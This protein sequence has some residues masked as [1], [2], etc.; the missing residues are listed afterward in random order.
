MKPPAN[1]LE[2][3]PGDSTRAVLPG[4]PR[5]A[6]LFADF[7]ELA[8]GELRWLAETVDQIRQHD[9]EDIFDQLYRRNHVLSGLASILALPKASHLL[10]VLD[11]LFDHA[12]A[13]PSF[14]RNSM[15]YLVKL[16]TDGTRAVLDDYQARG[17]SDLDLSDQIEECARYL[18][19]PLQSALAPPRP[20]PK[21]PVHASPDTGPAT[22]EARKMATDA[23]VPSVVTPEDFDDG[24]EELE[25]PLEMLGLISD[26]HEECRENLT[27]IGQ[28]L[29]A[30]EETN[31]TAPVV[32][33]LFRAVHTVKGG[34]RLLNIRKMEALAHR[35]ENLLDEVR[36]GTRTVDAVLIDVLLDGRKCLEQMV[37]EVASGGPIRTRIRPAL[38]AMAALEAGLAPA[39]PES[40]DAPK[41]T[42][43]PQPGDTPAP[44]PR[45]MAAPETASSGTAASA[46]SIRIATQKLDDVLNTAS[47]I[48][49]TRIRLQNDMQGIR[50]AVQQLDQMLHRVGQL[51]C[52]A[53]SERLVEANDHSRHNPRASTGHPN[54][55]IGPGQRHAVVDRSH[56]ELVADLKE[57][58]SAAEEISFQLL[59]IEEVRTRL[60]ENVDDL[61]QLTGRLQSSAMN[62]R[63][64]PIIQLFDRFPTQVREIARQLGKRV[65]FAVSGGNTELDKVLINQLADPLLHILRN[66]VDHGIEPSDERVRSGKPEVGHIGL[67][68]SYQGSY[69]V[70]EIADDGRGIDVEKVLA[71]AIE[72]GLVDRERAA[73]LGPS[74]ILEFIFEPGF[75][76]LTTVS[77]LSGRGVGMDVVRSAISQIQGSIGIDSRPGQGTSLRIKL[78]LTLAIIGILM[79]EEGPNQ[80]AFPILNVEEILH[81]SKDQIRQLS[82]NA[83]YN[84]RGKTLPVT[85]LSS[86]LGFPPSGFSDDR[87]ALVILTEGEKRI[88]VL[89]DAVVGRQE[90]L[91]K[92]LGS[93][94]RKVPFVMG[95]TISSD[96]RLVLILSAWEIVNRRPDQPAPRLGR[97]LDDRFEER[98]TH[99]VLVVEDSAMQRK[100]LSAILRQAGYPADNAENGFAALK[101]LREK[102][103]AAFCVDIV[104]PLMDGLEFVERLRQMP[105]HA[106]SAVVFVTGRTTVSKQDRAARLGVLDYLIKP[107]EPEVLIE[108]FDRH[109]LGVRASGAVQQ[110]DPAVV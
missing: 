67:R 62:F 41:A 32:N 40:S 30:L 23:V 109:C 94:I 61:E 58:E 31:E 60:Q 84:H 77:E 52:R 8:Q 44:E 90:V 55:Q 37:S 65:K 66:A 33:E 69:V 45:A 80:F 53:L 87:I 14:E 2:P 73:S 95:C 106:D 76:T 97:T 81:I 89:V 74:E 102:R 71:K 49:V 56:E 54:R 35:L 34:A 19:E 24:P 16:L 51:D 48:F 83:M 104:M 47:E 1:L 86:V 75:S 103:Y 78:P 99:A 39:A 4:D 107:V 13:I 68:A 70:I 3:W 93:L 100:R 101:Q 72:R 85:T 63:M 7:A 36:Q 29:I 10:A 91:I 11:F 96:S 57:Q 27:Q 42:P 6:A 20:E 28:G 26:F 38:Q 92:N 64:V 46:D 12:R 25:V 105:D 108:A 5:I 15:D 17:Q 9:D 79:V 21:I 50:G 110:T 43:E 98:Q 82:G 22:P 59:A 88:G 18:G